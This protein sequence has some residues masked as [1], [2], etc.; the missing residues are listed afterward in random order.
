[1]PLVFSSTIAVLF[2]Y[3]VQLFLNYV[4]GSNSSIA[5]SLLDFTRWV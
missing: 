2:A 3:P 4:L 5:N 1:M